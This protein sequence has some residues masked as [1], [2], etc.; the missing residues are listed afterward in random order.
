MQKIINKI[1]GLFK[2]PFWHV[3]LFSLLFLTIALNSVLGVIKA[4]TITEKFFQGFYYIHN[5]D[6]PRIL[7]QC[8]VVPFIFFSLV[9]I[10]L[11]KINNKQTKENDYLM[12]L[13]QLYI[14]N[15]LAGAITMLILAFVH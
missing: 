13:F 11:K 5:I 7:I 3:I 8:V 10:I 9:W 2:I 15:L 6:Y 12:V 1:E 4:E 14:Y